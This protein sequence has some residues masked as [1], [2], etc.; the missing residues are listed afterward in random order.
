LQA[1]SSD[2]GDRLGAP[3]EG[4]GLR[5]FGL[6]RFG[7][8]RRS[9]RQR[10]RPWA[11]SAALVALLALCC[12][13]SASA[14]GAASPPSA[15]CVFWGAAHSC[16][17]TNP[18]VTLEVVNE[19]E[20]SLCTFHE[21]WT[22]G[23]GSAAEEITLH[24][25]FEGTTQM[26]G[27]HTYS[28]PGSYTI[29]VSGYVVS[30]ESGLE[31]T[32]EAPTEEYSFTLLP[33]SGVLGSKEEQPVAPI[34]TNFTQAHRKWREGKKLAKIAHAQKPPVGTAFSFA[35]NEQATVNLAFVR[36]LTGRIVRGKCVQGTPAVPRSSC[37]RLQTVGSLSFTGRAGVS[38]VSFQGRLSSAKKLAPGTYTLTITATNTAK[39]QSAPRSLTF[40][41]VR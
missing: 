28:H 25:S 24:G 20:T 35:L 4:V 13:G 36:Q 10:R 17:S 2:N 38:T 32:C 5:R 30:E 29:S 7:L 8:R 34:I 40:T 1:L 18:Q 16:E 3:M 41:V 19:R 11:I 33:G 27:A 15:P 31:Y 37:V 14:A 12:L 9:P 39:Q 26:L 6:R 22:W 21:T 23:D